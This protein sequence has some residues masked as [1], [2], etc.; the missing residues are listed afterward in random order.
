MNFPVAVPRKT[1]HILKLVGFS[2]VEGE[3]DGIHQ[4]KDPL[5]GLLLVQLFPVGQG[6]GQNPVVFTE[7][8]VETDAWTRR[9]HHIPLPGSGIPWFLELQV[10]ETGQNDPFPFPQQ[11]LD[12]VADDHCQEFIR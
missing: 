1:S 3:F 5:S 10:P 7:P 8:S 6:I 11:T 2:F 12:M 4:F 9:F